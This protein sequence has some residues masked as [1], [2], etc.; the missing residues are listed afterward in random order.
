[1]EE[2]TVGYDDVC[3]TELEPGNLVFV[4]PGDHSLGGIPAFVAAASGEAVE[5]EFPHALYGRMP[6]YR[7]QLREIRFYQELPAIEWR[8]GA[9]VFAYKRVVFNPPLFLMFPATVLQIH[10]ESFAEVEFGDGEH[11]YVPI[12][13]VEKFDA[14]EGDFVHTCTSFVS[15]GTNPDERWS[16]C[17]VIERVGEDLV[18]QEGTG[19]TFRTKM[20]MV[21]ILPKGY[22]MFDGKFER[23]P[24]S[25]APGSSHV[26]I[27]RT[28]RWQ[29][30][31][32]API[33]KNDVDELIVSD[34]E[35]AWSVAKWHDEAKPFTILWQGAPCFWWDR[36]EIVCEKPSGEQLAKMID[37][38]V[39]LDANVLGADGTEYH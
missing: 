35:L 38:A 19:E 31:A 14:Q 22:Q 39:A 25:G 8:N 23:I 17:R 34:S 3:Q 9:L 13:L 18:V 27:V 32:N 29:D 11:A 10:Q 36:H 37:I 26:H 1:M 20:S 15:H 16:P 30:A 6:N 2:Y 5:L 33:T 7:Y 4:D 12:T 28:D 24:P 21:A